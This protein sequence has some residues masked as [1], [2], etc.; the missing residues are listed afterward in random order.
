M[1]RRAAVLSILTLFGCR[2]SSLDRGSKARSVATADS[3]RAAEA[4]LWQSVHQHDSASFARY[5]APDYLMLSGVG[6]ADRPREVELGLHFGGDLQLD[7][8]RLY[9]WRRRW[10]TDSVLVLNYY[11]Q[12]WGRYQGQAIKQLAGAMAVWRRGPAGW[13]SVVHTEFDLPPELWD[14]AAVVQ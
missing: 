8:F 1:N 7:S 3:V 6:H 13:Q 2:T 11:S 10:I 5:L 9:H 12:A 14:T 4:S